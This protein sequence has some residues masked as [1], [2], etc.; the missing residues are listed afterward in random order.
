MPARAEVDAPIEEGRRGVPFFAE[1][2]GVD[3]LPL[4]GCRDD[5]QGAALAEQVNLA[6]AGYG[7]SIVVAAA[8]QAADRRT[9]T[10]NGMHDD[11]YYEAQSAVQDPKLIRAEQRIKAGLFTL[12]GVDLAPVSKTVEL[13]KKLAVYRAGITAKAF[14]ASQKK[15]RGN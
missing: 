6:V 12:H 4:V 15:L 2:G 13:G 1:L 14:Q 5:R 3:H 8:G 10:R 7:G 9:D 11:V